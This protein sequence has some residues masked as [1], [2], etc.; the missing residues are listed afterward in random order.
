MSIEQRRITLFR[1]DDGRWTARDETIGVTTRASTRA[2]A[3]ESLDEAVEAAPD[4]GGPVSGPMPGFGPRPEEQFVTN[5]KGFAFVR[6]I[7]DRIKR[8]WY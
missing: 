1:T 8:R 2:H 3:L 6:R 5:A 4:A 7:A